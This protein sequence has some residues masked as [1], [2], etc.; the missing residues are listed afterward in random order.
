MRRRGPHPLTVLAALCGLFIVYGTTIPFEPVAEPI[1]LA[2]GWRRAVDAAPRRSSRTDRAANVLLFMPL[3]AMIAARLGRAGAGP[4]GSVLAASAVG[5]ALSAGVETL[6]INL[7]M[8]VT[9][10]SDLMNNTIGS[11][12]GGGLGWLAGRWAWPWFWPALKRGAAT[13]PLASLAIVATVGWGVIELAPFV[14]SADVGDLKSAVKSARPI[15]F[16]PSVDGRRPAPDP[17]AWAVEAL[18]WSLLGG[19]VALAVRERG[20]R[21]V[22]LVAETI[23]LTAGFR[24][25]VE[26]V[27][28]GFPGHVTDATSVVLTSAGATASALAVAIRPRLPA[29]SWIGPGLAVWAAAVLI[30]GASP[31]DA[32][33]RPRSLDPRMAFP[34]YSY[35][36][37]PPTSALATAAEKVASMVPLGFLLAARSRRWTPAA[38]ALSGWAAGASIEAIQLFNASRT[39][40]M[41][42]A[43]LAALGAWLGGRALRSW[44]SAGASP[45]SPTT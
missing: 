30:D 1:P 27:Q 19:L 15:P 25:A 26:L 21:G 13:H 3:G 22:E 10:V 9:S 20:G 35:F 11:A 2:E 14:P 45:S 37:S 38:S 28:L 4:I 8:R 23:V 12:I 40:D 34:F 16:G 18:S 43:F 32:F 41:T 44:E 36:W 29:R 24:A 17:W 6:Q 33:G 42:D 5:A 39:P 31:F 7:Q